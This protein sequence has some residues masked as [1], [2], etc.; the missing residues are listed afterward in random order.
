MTFSRSQNWVYELRFWLFDIFWYI[1]TA[2]HHPCATYFTEVTAGPPD[3]NVWEKCSTCKDTHTQKETASSRDIIVND[4]TWNVSS[5]F[6]PFSS[7]VGVARDKIYL[8]QLFRY[9]NVRPHRK[10]PEHRT[11]ETSPGASSFLPCGWRCHILHISEVPLTQQINKLS[12]NLNGAQ[13]ICP[14]P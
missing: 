11:K 8:S 9:L 1:S 4:D 2:L 6:Q 14:L 12:I 7:L 5:S 3:L 10:S 13:L